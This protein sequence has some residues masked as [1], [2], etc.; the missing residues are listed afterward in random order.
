MF[1]SAI[2]FHSMNSIQFFP[3][4][5]KQGSFG[6]QSI[7][8]IL[9]ERPFMAGSMMFAQYSV[10]KTL[11][12]QTNRDTINPRATGGSPYPAEPESVPVFS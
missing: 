7:R 9:P 3:R 4:P 6:L 1:E 2:A 8:R 10:Q 12:T 5:R 11:Y